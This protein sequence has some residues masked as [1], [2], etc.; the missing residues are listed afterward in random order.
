MLANERLPPGPPSDLGQS[1]HVDARLRRRTATAA[2]KGG[3]LAQDLAPLTEGE[4]QR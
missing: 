2:P 1:V 4:R 3:R